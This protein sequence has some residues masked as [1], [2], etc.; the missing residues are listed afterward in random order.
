M[1]GVLGS[2]P[3]VRTHKEAKAVG[4]GRPYVGGR[5]ELCAV[6]GEQLRSTALPQP[7]SGTHTEVARR[8][9]AFLESFFSNFIEGT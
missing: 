3:S 1:A 8:H 2:R 4:A 5:L 9:F 7:A 6:L